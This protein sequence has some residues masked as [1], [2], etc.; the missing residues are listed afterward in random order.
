MS[1]K[2]LS[3]KVTIQNDQGLHARPSTLV[4]ETASQF[5]AEVTIIKDDIVVDGKSILGVMGLGAAYGECIEVSTTGPDAAEA[6][7]AITDL[8]EQGFV[9]TES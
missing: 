6:L 5:A 1:T 3:K 9:T 4:V 8:V 2:T 7:A